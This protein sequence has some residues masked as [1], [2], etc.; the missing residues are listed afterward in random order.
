MYNIFIS[1]TWR[2]SNAYYRGLIRLLDEADKFD[3]VALSVPNLHRL[4][5]D[6]VRCRGWVLKAL[7]AADAVLVVDTPMDINSPLVQSEL[8]VAERHKIPIVAINPPKSHGAAKAS[9]FAANARAYS[10][11][12][13]SQDIL[14]AIRTA[15]R[16]MPRVSQ[17]KT[18][19][20]HYAYESIAA[21]AA[22]EPLTLM[23]LE[24]VRGD[25]EAAISA[26]SAA[27]ARGQRPRDVLFRQRESLISRA[28]ALLPLLVRTALFSRS[29]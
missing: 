23:E 2:A 12:W 9:E 20:L 29:R 1:H 28:S 18:P 8:R 15:V 14:D 5:S 26:T 13:T 17:A 21:A 16:E 25:D 27:K 22:G 7:K 3:I 4:E 6:T 10:A 24:A 11:R 19:L